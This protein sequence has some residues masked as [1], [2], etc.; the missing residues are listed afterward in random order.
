MNSVII[1]LK[2]PVIRI[3][4][5]VKLNDEIFIA[6]FYR[7]KWIIFPACL[8]VTV[9][10]QPN[11]AYVGKTNE[12]VIFKYLLFCFHLYLQFLKE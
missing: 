4:F 3:I 6:A 8:N 9:K 1:T 7:D 5:N 10:Y 2:S 11:I 12:D